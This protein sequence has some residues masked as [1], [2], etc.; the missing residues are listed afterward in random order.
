MGRH[1]LRGAG[2]D[3]LSTALAALGPEVN[4]PI[5]G[6]DDV[7]I[8]FDDC[9]RM[10]GLHEFAKGPEQ[11]S[12]IIEMQA[13]RRLVKE[14][15]SA[16]H[17]FDGLRRCRRRCGRLLGRGL[18]LASFTGL[19]RLSQKAREFEALCFAPGE[20]RN[21]L[22][23]GQIVEANG[24]QWPQPREDF[25][26]ARKGH[27][28]FGN[29]EFQDI[30]DGARNPIRAIDLDLEH[31]SPIAAA[32]AVL[33]AQV[34]VRKKLHLDVFEPIPAA[35]GAATIARVRAERRDPVTAFSGE[36]M[37]GKSRAN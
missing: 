3:E 9:H 33:A 11:S 15:Q 13:S 22:S 5:G 31:F 35:G 6:P 34:H 19:G 8:V 17:R 18:R 29:G 10:P 37:T 12:H 2:H 16:S 30:G 32:V 23:Q 7:Q 20:R 14:I 28:G 27:Q 4:H 26:V 1:G 21:G 24:R 36:R 25:A